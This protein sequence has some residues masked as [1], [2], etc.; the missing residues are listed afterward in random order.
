MKNTLLSKLNWKKRRRGDF[1][2]MKADTFLLLQDMRTAKE[3]DYSW[4]YLDK[5]HRRKI[6]A[7]LENGW[8]IRSKGGDLDRDR[9]SI[10]NRGLEALKIY[11]A[12]LFSRNKQKSNY[13]PIEQDSTKQMC[14]QCRVRPKLVYKNG[15]VCTY[16]RECRREY[17]RNYYHEVKR[18]LKS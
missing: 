6:H 9:Y 4:V 2:P 18:R 3:A 16:C 17:A 11:E 15:S 8:I 14:S 1:P 7:M 12:P 13:P 5:V 10:T